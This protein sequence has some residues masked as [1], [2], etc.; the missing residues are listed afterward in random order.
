[1]S[2][3]KIPIRLLKKHF[4]YSV[5]QIGSLGYLVCACGAAFSLAGSVKE[6]SERE[7][8]RWIR[9]LETLL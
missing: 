1:M 5:T 7:T 8:D 3:K 9:H 4:G 2:E 6:D